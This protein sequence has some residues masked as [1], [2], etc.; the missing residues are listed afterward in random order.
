MYCSEKLHNLFMQVT[1]T[2]WFFVPRSSDSGWVYQFYPCQSTAYSVEHCHFWVYFQFILNYYVWLEVSMIPSSLQF[3]SRN[4]C[5]VWLKSLLA[6]VC[7]VYVNFCKLF[8]L[9]YFS[10]QFQMSPDSNYKCPFSCAFSSKTS[11]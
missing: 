9:H 2:Q 5:Y 3:I 11:Y 7:P 10:P 4:R 8:F 1:L 6:L